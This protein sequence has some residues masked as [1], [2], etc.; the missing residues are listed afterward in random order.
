[1][2]DQWEQILRAPQ[3]SFSD[4][5][6]PH[7]KFDHQACRERVCLFCLKKAFKCRSFINEMWKVGYS[8]DVRTEGVFDLK[9]FP[10]IG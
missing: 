4:Q 10:E 1:M 2:F 8:Y 7:L 5:K 6:M 3:D 9:R